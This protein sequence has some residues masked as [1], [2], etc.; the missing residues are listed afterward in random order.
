MSRR[1]RAEKRQVIPD[2]KYGDE[3]LSKFM[4]SLMLHGKKSTAERILYG[5]LDNIEGKLSREPVAVFHEALEN[6]MPPLKCVRAAS[7]V[8]LIRCR[9]KCALTA[10]RRWPFAGSFQ[11]LVVVAKTP[12][13]TASPVS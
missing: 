5:A 11:P 3:V 10:S 9:L 8:P 6:I 4:N 7:A 1:H 12:W 2:A 13:L